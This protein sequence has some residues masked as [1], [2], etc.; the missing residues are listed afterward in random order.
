MKLY[1]GILEWEWNKDPFMM[2]LWSR[3]LV[4]ANYRD[5]RFRGMTIKRGQILTSLRKLSEESGL[6]VRVVRTC[7]S[8]LK[9]TQEVTLLATHDYTL[10]T[11]CNYDKYQSSLD[12]SDTV[13][14]TVSDT[15]ATQQRHSNMYRIEERK[16]INIYSGDNASARVHA[17]AVE[18]F[19]QGQIALNTFCKDEGIDVETCRVLADEVV[20]DWALSGETHESVR[21]ARRHLLHLIRIKLNRKR[22]NNGQR[23]KSATET[24]NAGNPLARARVHTAKIGSEH[25]G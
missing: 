12:M 11:I 4:M 9:E 24:G 10:I 23:N 16:N 6:S 18:E 2:A 5:T 3:L 1:E 13:S 7:L 8:R 17:Q 25:E 22:Q 15:A 21:D 14:D 20:N 19:F